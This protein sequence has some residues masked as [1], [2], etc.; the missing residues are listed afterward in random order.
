MIFQ[1]DKIKQ[2]HFFNWF[3]FFFFMLKRLTTVCGMLDY[4]IN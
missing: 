2:K 3:F 4:F 1:V